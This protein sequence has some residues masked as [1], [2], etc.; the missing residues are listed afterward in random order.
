MLSFEA[1]SREKLMECNG[2]DVRF[3]FDTLFYGLRESLG[4]VKFHFNRDL[5]DNILLRGLPAETARVMKG[6]PRQHMPTKL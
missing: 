2:E 6:E 1:E 5:T 3:L 4:G